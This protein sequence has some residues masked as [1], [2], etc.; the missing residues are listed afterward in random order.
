MVI[1]QVRQPLKPYVSFLLIL[2][3]AGLAG[4]VQLLIAAVGSGTY[5]GYFRLL[6]PTQMIPMV[7][8]TGLS[9]WL[10]ILSLKPG[11]SQ[12]ISS[13]INRLTSWFRSL[14]WANWLF[15]AIFW[16][17]FSVLFFSTITSSLKHI[18][19]SIWMFTILWLPCAAFLSLAWPKLR[20]YDHLL[21]VLLSLGCFYQ[22]AFY[23]FK[24]NNDP[25]S[26]SW[27]EGSQLYLAS[28]FF[29]K[30]LYGVSVPLPVLHPSYE[31]LMA[32]PFLIHG[33]P[34]WVHRLWVDFLW[35]GCSLT[36][37]LV[38]VRHFP[39]VRLFRK[40][41][42]VGWVFLFLLQIS[43]FF[44]LLLCVI[45]VLVGFSSKNRWVRL[46]AVLAASIWAGISRINWWP[47]PG[48]LGAVIYIMETP[49]GNKG[50]RYFMTPVLWIGQEQ[51]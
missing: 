45:I 15:F 8:I 16:L 34:I 17:F 42:C 27:S 33:L 36:T 3:L 38:L 44:H 21:L 26:A 20:Y 1:N 37:G 30:S 11:A 50:W 4:L 47:M 23:L 29:S 7:I 31:L 18:I 6:R 14:G 5:P 25:F 24:L 40:I 48:F 32:I 28:T 13:F 9:G 22:V 43:V 10:L 41:L 39:K 49:L 35:L 12:K 2:T 51:E 46:G 19:P